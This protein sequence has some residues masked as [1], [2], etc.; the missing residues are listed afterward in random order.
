MSIFL[1]SHGGSGNHGCEAI[2]RGTKEILPDEQMALY[3]FKKAEDEKY[4]LGQLV[5]LGCKN[6]IWK[7]E[8]SQNSSFFENPSV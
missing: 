5:N 6:I 7:A 1:Y 4:G 8:Y 3:S 2:V